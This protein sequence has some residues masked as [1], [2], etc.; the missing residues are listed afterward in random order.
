MK[1]INK[2][3]L[4]KTSLMMTIGLFLII[5][6][7]FPVGTLFL[8]AFYA[9][10]EFVGIE[11]FKEYFRT[12]ALMSSLY[13]S[14]FVATVATIIAFILAFIFAYGIERTNIKYKKLFRTIGLLPLFAP[15]M[16]HGIALIY[17]FGNKGIIT[18]G[19]FGK[20]NQV[21]FRFPV[22]GKWG[23]IFAE[24][25]YVFPAIFLMI[26]IAFKM[27]DHRLYE[28]AE[29]FGVN[30]FKRF[31]S[32]TLPSIKYS[33]VSAL[34]ASF[35]MVFTDFGAPKVLGGNYNLLSTD[36]YKYVIGQQNIAMGAT[37]GMLLIIPSVMVFV[38]D[39]IINRRSSSIDSKAK[40]YVIQENKVRD[41]IS[42]VCNVLISMIIIIIFITVFFASFVKNWPYDLSLTLKWYNINTFGVSALEIYKNTIL[43]SIMTALLGTL[44]VFLTAYMTER[45]NIFKKVRKGLY[46]LSTLPLS[47][48]GLVIGLSFVLFFNSKDNVLNF[49]YGTFAILV[50]A[51]I[52]HFFSVPFLSITS[53]MKKIDKEY[54]SVSEALGVPW[55]KVLINVIIPMSVPALLESFSYYFVNSMMTISAVVFLYTSKTRIASVEMVNRYD[56]GDVATATAVAV[57]IILT[58]IIFK[59]IFNKAVEIYSVIKNK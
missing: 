9:K 24:I 52:V 36:I 44:I 38:V 20:V 56:N 8:N 13:N 23:V 57:M 59:I 49:I 50:I 53:N 33:V 32:I 43:V 48:P 7:V 3:N 11:N 19:F 42:L 21:A 18:T 29:V 17:L 45:S 22:Y 58:N 14:F 26:S 40:N 1:N 6:I 51:N 31:I 37:V 47:L 15:T 5:T 12:P 46:F 16:T 54:E 35:T 39:Q 28:A 30:K 34:F 4:M 25:I 27:S 2:S 41:L 55:Y 10:N